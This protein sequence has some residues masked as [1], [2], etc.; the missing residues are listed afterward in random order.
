MNNTASTDQ[1]APVRGHLI[2]VE[3]LD[4]SGKTTQCQ[5]LCE[6]IGGLDKEFKYVKFP[7]TLFFIDSTTSI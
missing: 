1:K 5:S 7:G 4:R 2:V 3:G 6:D